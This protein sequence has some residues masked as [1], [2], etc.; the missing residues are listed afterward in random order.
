MKLCKILDLNVKLKD[1][2]SKLL[3]ELTVK[4]EEKVLK[5]DKCEVQWCII[6]TNREL[7]SLIT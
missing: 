4:W 6:A 2:E 1:D 7:H 5:V 3:P